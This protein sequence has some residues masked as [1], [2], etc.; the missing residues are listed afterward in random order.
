MDTQ[1][2]QVALEQLHYNWHNFSIQ[3]FAAHISQLRQRPL[4]LIGIALNDL[5]GICISTADGDY[6]FYDHQRHPTLQL[7]TILH[8]IAHLVLNHTTS[9][10][11]GTDEFSGI[12]LHINARAQRQLH[13]PDLRREEDEAEY[14]AFLAQRTI[15]IVQ[16]QALAQQTDAA[17]D[18]HIPP[19]TDSFFAGEDP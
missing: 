12:L 19:F 5:S 2:V 11:H 1:R 7:H 9:S 3:N 6:V 4:Q 18:S 15:A 17:A 14:F 13:Q 10:L 16:R 8:E